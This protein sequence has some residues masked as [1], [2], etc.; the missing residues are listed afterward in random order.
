M[1]LDFRRRTPLATLQ[2]IHALPVLGRQIAPQKAYACCACRRQIGPVGTLLY[3][4]VLTCSDDRCS[5]TKPG[6]VN[7]IFNTPYGLGLS[8]ATLA[9]FCQLIELPS[10]RVV[11][12]RQPIIDRAEILANAL[13]KLIAWQEAFDT[14][15]KLT[16]PDGYDRGTVRVIPPRRL[17]D[18]LAFRAADQPTPVDPLKGLPE[19]LQITLRRVLTKG[20]DAIEVPF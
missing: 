7:E 6:D 12:Q 14:W 16:D 3:P 8:R 13:D 15:E 1:A 17:D 10:G 5:F 11:V 9:I 19:D 20:A 2:R 18:V 4:G